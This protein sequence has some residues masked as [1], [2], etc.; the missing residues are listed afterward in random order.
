MPEETDEVRLLR[1]ILAWTRFANRAAFVSTLNQVLADPRHL[2]AY[3]LSDGTRGQTTIANESRLS[4]PTIST[5]WSKWRRLGL[6]M[7]E[8][9]RARHLIRP[10]DV[11]IDI[12][13]LGA[14]APPTEVAS[15][16]AQ[17]D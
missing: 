14:Q 12:P 10:S 11:G 3:E 2:I 7:D 8:G 6:V 16:P 1:E 5:L 9:G 4:Q 13:K 17:E 15:A